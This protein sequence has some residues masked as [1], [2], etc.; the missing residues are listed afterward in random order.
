[1]GPNLKLRP[2]RRLHKSRLAR[3]IYATTALGTAAAGLLL[4][5]PQSQALSGGSARADRSQSSAGSQSSAAP[6]G[7]RRRTA[8]W[9]YDQGHQTACGFVAKYGVANK[10]LPCGTH[11]RF[12]RAGHRVTAIVDDRGPYVPGRTWDLGQNTA[13]ALHFMRIGV[14]YVWAKW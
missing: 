5:A 12:W 8:S 6:A 4:T 14:G 3:G 7:Y 9:Y 13:R 10:K 1:M 11:V 2:H